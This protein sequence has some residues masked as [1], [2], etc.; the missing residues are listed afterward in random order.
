LPRPIL[1][2]AVLGLSIVGCLAGAAS[3]AVLIGGVGARTRPFIAFIASQPT[4]YLP[5]G[6]AM[7]FATVVDLSTEEG[8]TRR[9]VAAT[10]V[11][12]ALICVSAA[13][14]I[15]SLVAVNPIEPSR[16]LIIACGLLAWL[17]LLP[18]VRAA[19][20][21]LLVRGPR[22]LHV[23]LTRSSSRFGLSFL[24]VAVSLVMGAACFALLLLPH[25]RSSELLVVIPAFVLAW[26]AGFVALPF[27]SGIGVRELVLALLL[28]GHPAAAIMA[29]SLTQRCVVLI[30]ELLLM[31][32]TWKRAYAPGAA[33]PE[34]RT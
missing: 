34:A 11:L 32:V 7:Q 27:P 22:V 9:D 21:R 8:G 20:E 19:L 15:G 6:G 29:A 24:W 3:W 33:P 31:G 13:C 10:F 17:I 16:R 12:H 2:A 4:K 14:A 23:A 28:P 30:A 26:C 1:F 5:L 25:P 18:S